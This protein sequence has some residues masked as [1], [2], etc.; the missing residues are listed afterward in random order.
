MTALDYLVFMAQLFGLRKSVARAGARDLLEFFGLEE[1]TS[2]TIAEFSGGN[3]TES[4][5]CIHANTRAKIAHL[6]RTDYQP[7]PRGE[8]EHHRL[9]KATLN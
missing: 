1:E 7:G 6:G 5:S 9:H 4:R 8:K 2:K 3:E